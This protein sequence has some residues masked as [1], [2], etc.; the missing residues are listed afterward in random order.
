MIPM[1]PDL[2]SNPPRAR[3]LCVRVACLL[4][5]CASGPAVAARG[6][7][8][9][10]PFRAARL[11]VYPPS[12]A[13]EGPRDAR[14][15]LVTGIAADGTRIDLSNEAR[16]V[17]PKDAG[18]RFD[19]QG[20][21][22]GTRDGA[23]TARVEAGGT[24]VDLPIMVK[25]AARPKPVSFVREVMPA[26]S[27]IG[28]NAGTCHGSAKGKKGFKLS[29]RGY[30]LAWDYEQ[31]VDDLAGRRFNRAAPDQ[32][33]MLLK[34]TMGVP[35]EGGRVLE[36]ES[37]RY[38]LIR[39]W[40]AEGV[41]SDVASTPR[42][43]SIEVYPKSTNL[44]REGRLQQLLVIAK[45]PDGT[46]RDV[47]EDAIFSSS[48]PDVATVSPA[49]VVTSVR[50][51]EASILVRYEGAFAVDNV[52]VMGDRTGFA[53]APQPELNEIDRLVDA[54]LQKIKVNAAP[55]CT[56][57]EF[58]RRVSFDLT[59]LPPT[60]ER[61]RSFLADGTDSRTKRE[62]VV[63][64]L[65]GS[66]AFVSHWTHKWAD[67]LEVN[68]KFLGDKATW[69]FLRWIERAVWT[70]MPYDQMVRSVVVAEGS[71][72]DNPP[73][74]Y[75]RTS[76]EPSVAL[77]NATQLFLGVR[78]S[79]NKCHDHPFEKWTQG[80]YYGMAAFWA[81]VGMKPGALSDE[82]VVFDRNQGEVT[83]P[84]DGRVMTPTFPYQFTR[85]SGSK[86]KADSSRREQLADW[87]TAPEN[88]F[89]ARSIVNR[90]WSYFLGR[91]IIDPVDDIRSS[92]PASNPELLDM[93]ERDFLAH[94]FDLRHL[95]RTIARSRTYQASIATTKWNVDDLANFSHATPRRLT[96]EELLDAIDVATGR[97]P[98]FAGVPAGFRAEQLPD[99]QV[100]GGG[101]LDLFGRPPRES[102][103]ECER[104]SEVSLGQA[105]NL[106]NGPTIAEALIDPAGRVATFLKSKPDDAKIVEEMYL[107]ALSRRPNP[108]EIEKGKAYLAAS[109]S[110]A[111]GAQDLLWALMNSPSFLF[112]R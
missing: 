66:P 6:D 42:A 56:D 40:I 93:L 22:H 110:K 95:M 39:T 23:F 35:H 76:R 54:K 79:C 78:F 91:G 7:Q 8:K 96:A 21:A 94:S 25:N 85:A 2:K 90:V 43:A 9:P 45:Y 24:S 11:E 30:D 52:L 77:E 71:S 89:F 74:N 17:A 28:C 12:L 105:L 46:D 67:L 111:E 63:D 48:V 65:I 20:G 73:V 87:L 80:Q 106:V 33:L 4:A 44:D 14:R 49:G 84:R 15:V 18:V 29:L 16:F 75:Y 108:V 62:R 10:S 88:P 99:S 69:A 36:P 68:R 92:N 107:A 81:Q 31:F 41:N 5:V 60:P 59:G 37:P 34:P 64:E 61:V 38:E 97:E 101:F 26:L 55:L 47:T 72:F 112:N 57:A 1:R 51:G 53:W 100:A 103:C 58:L 3:V 19:A 27:R 82:Q 86:A 70:N 32:S 13:L 50:R 98:R 109:T 83:H 102:P 104:S